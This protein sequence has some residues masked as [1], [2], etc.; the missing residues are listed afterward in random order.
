MPEPPWKFLLARNWSV[1]EAPLVLL[2]SKVTRLH[3]EVEPDGLC[4]TPSHTCPLCSKAR[5][6]VSPLTGWVMYQ[7]EG[8]G[9]IAPVQVD[10][11]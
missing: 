5:N 11:G 3:E 4:Q 8:S 1:M 9:S 7:K 6:K 2:R 10:A